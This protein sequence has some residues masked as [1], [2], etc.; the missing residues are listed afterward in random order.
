MLRLFL[1]RSP[2]L[3]GLLGSQRSL[4]LG[5]LARCLEFGGPPG[6]RNFGFPARLFL[7]LPTLGFLLGGFPRCLGLQGSTLGLLGRLA[8]GVDFGGSSGRLFLRGLAGLGGRGTRSL[9]FSGSLGGLFFSLPARCLRFRGPAVCIFLG[10]PARDFEFCHAADSL[11]DRGAMGLGFRRPARSLLLGGLLRGLSFRGPTLGFLLG[12]P[13][14]GLRLFGP[15]GRLFLGGLACCF[16]CV[17][18]GLQL[19]GLDLGF[20]LCG[21]PG[22]LEFCGLP[23]GLL[24]RL[25]A[26]P[27][28]FL[29]L[30]LQLRRLLLQLS[31]GLPA[32]LPGRCDGRLE[33]LSRLPGFLLGRLPSGFDLGRPAIRLFFGRLA[34]KSRCFE[35]RPQLLFLHTCALFR[36]FARGLVIRCPV[37]CLLVGPS[38]GSL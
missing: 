25:P 27:L 6:C 9:E 7:D 17:E 23:G 30:R 26:C 36:R 32:C 8:G 3:G 11:V 33:S 35:R 18:G 15:A 21:E 13:D 12:C 1:R 10:F 22:R 4:L 34:G 20:L 28:Y 5:G 14:C 31:F 37:R 24:F 19:R 2:G 29:E 16:R 38:Q